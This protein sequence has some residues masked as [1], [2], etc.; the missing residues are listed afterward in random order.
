MVSTNYQA[1]ITRGYVDWRRIRKSS[2]KI[3]EISTD[4][5]YQ[6]KLGKCCTFD[7]GYKLE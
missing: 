4:F 3:K 6:G 2:K 1:Y 5:K 7:L